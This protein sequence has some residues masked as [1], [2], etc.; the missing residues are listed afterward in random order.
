M[1]QHHTPKPSSGAVHQIKMYGKDAPEGIE[2][3]SG[4][5]VPE[6]SYTLMPDSPDQRL[7]I[8]LVPKYKREWTPKL[9]VMQTELMK[10][11][12]VTV[13]VSVSGS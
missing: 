12:T 9:A 3:A 6:A 8:I 1:N 11:G 7:F 5:Q 4:R 10:K 13:T 2:G